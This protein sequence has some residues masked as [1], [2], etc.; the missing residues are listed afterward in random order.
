VFTPEI[1]DLPDVWPA[2]RRAQ[3]GS[4]AAVARVDAPL[5]AVVVACENGHFRAYQRKD[6]F[7]RGGRYAGLF[8]PLV[9]A[10]DAPRGARER[11]LEAGERRRSEVLEDAERCALCGTPPVE[12]PYRPDLD[13]RGDRET[14][15]WLGRWRP[16]LYAQLLEAVAI[17]GRRE[18]VTFGTWRSAI[19]SRLR[20][21]VVAELASSALQAD[22]LVPAALLAQLVDALTPRE[23]D[24]AVN[25]LLVPLCRRCDNG[26]WRRRQSCE[27]YLREYV[28]ALH[29]GD[30]R[31][32]RADAAQWRMME[33]IAYHAAR[34]GP[35]V[36]AAAAG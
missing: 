17:A 36:S 31:I 10:P 18:P 8:G 28:V 14:W 24:F 12:H 34:V 35:E 22:H 26:R 15:T 13:V 11:R 30:E 27:D 5:G 19:P 25:R 16:A 1:V 3:C 33:S 9:L 2:C 4:T 7:R 20:E 6:D 29:G 32:A 23:L 21:A